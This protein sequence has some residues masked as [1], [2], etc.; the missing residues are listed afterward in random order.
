MIAE[1]AC[2]MKMVPLLATILGNPSSVQEVIDL[3]KV[4]LFSYPA[5]ISLCG[6]NSSFLR[7]LVGLLNSVFLHSMPDYFICILSGDTISDSQ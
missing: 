6:S 7:G 4:F 5:N 1:E 3:R 2:L